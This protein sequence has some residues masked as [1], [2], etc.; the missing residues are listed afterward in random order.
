MESRRTNRVWAVTLVA[1]ALT[2]CGA[3]AARADQAEAEKYLAERGLTKV[4]GYFVLGDEPDLTKLMREADELKKKVFD[5]Q[6]KVA[7]AEKVVEAK[8]KLIETYFQQRSQLR[9]RL[10]QNLP[11]AQHNQAVLM[12]S[13]LGDRIVNLQQATKE[14]DD[15]RAAQTEENAA[16]EKYVEHLM[17]V[18][19]LLDRVAEK[20]AD[21]AADPRVEDAIA[22]YNQG[23]TTPCK[24]GPGGVFTAADKRL[25][26][27]EDTVLSDSIPL[28]KG[29]GNLWMVSAMFSGKYAQE[30]CIDT[31]ASI[32]CLPWKIAADVGARPTEQSPVVKLTLADGRVVE[33]QMVSID[34]LRVGKFTVE[35]VDL[36]VMPENLTEASPLLG[37]SFLKHFTF[38]IDTVNEKLI[39]SKIESKD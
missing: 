16:T 39:M 1:G 9:V 17:S 6:R 24:L 2:G 4:G 5:A 30:L 3:A 37:Q 10:A 19:K 18:R 26:K 32:C 7:A 38:K 13:E 15:L 23:S 20:Y 27:M 28:R 31:G 25:K 21:L 22:Q 14:E 34:S 8:K 33:A 36:A 29:P 12:L 35:N 11:S